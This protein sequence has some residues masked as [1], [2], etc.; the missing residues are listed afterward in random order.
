M[1]ARLMSG[2]S[3]SRLHLLD[4]SRHACRAG[5]PGYRRLSS[6]EAAVR[7]AR[8]DFTC[9][10]H[11]WPRCLEFPGISETSAEAEVEVRASSHSLW[12]W[13]D[14]RR[15]TV[16]VDRETRARQALRGSFRAVQEHVTRRARESFSVPMAWRVG[17]AFVHT[18]R[19]ADTM[20]HVARDAKS[21]RPRRSFTEEFR[22]GA[23]RL[24]LDE[25]KTEPC[26]AA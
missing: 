13:A 12:R 26:R 25:V 3:A 20:A 17:L 14:G 8:R 18:F 15:L 1:S 22:A 5:P 6:V 16:V 19:K 11:S 24:V 7:R 23:V 21:R 10:S 9:S 4:L 2:P